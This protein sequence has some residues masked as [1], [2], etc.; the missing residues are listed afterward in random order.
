MNLNQFNEVLELLGKDYRIE[1]TSEKDEDGD[2]VWYFWQVS[3]S[4]ERSLADQDLHWRYAM[5]RFADTIVP[6]M[7]G[8]I[9]E[10]EHKLASLG[11]AG[12]LK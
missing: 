10:L 7:H 12:K 2:K 9:L 8:R 1:A 11:D 6:M 3:K 5:D 4:G